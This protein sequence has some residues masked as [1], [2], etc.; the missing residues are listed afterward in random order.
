MSNYKKVNIKNVAPTN[1]ETKTPEKY[2][3]PE[4]NEDSP[5]SAGSPTKEGFEKIV[6]RTPWDMAFLLFNKIGGNIYLATT[7]F[8]ALLLYGL[9]ISTG[10][11]KNKEDFLW[12]TLSIIVTSLIIPLGN[13]LFN[14]YNSSKKKK[15]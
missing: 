3:I 10:H 1:D 6:G 11:L 15:E 9:A 5:T 2:D 7:S 12:I 14:L 4:E 8:F 13:F